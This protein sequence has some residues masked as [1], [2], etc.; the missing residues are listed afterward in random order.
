M[1]R[2]DNGLNGYKRMRIRGLGLR[3][4]AKRLGVQGFDAYPTPLMLV[5][6]T[7]APTP[8]AVCIAALGMILLAI[9]MTIMPLEREYR[10]GTGCDNL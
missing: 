2:Y 1:G 5:L 6:E 9:E 10:N 7:L 8:S 4:S 3:C